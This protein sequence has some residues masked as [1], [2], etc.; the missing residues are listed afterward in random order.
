MKFSY[1]RAHSGQYL[2]LHVKSF[3]CG[4]PTEACHLRLDVQGCLCRDVTG[5]GMYHL[6]HQ[7]PGRAFTG[8]SACREPVRDK[9]KHHLSSTDSPSLTIPVFHSIPGFLIYLL[10]LHMMIL[11]RLFSFLNRNWGPAEGLHCGMALHDDFWFT[12][13][14]FSPQALSHREMLLVVHAIPSPSNSSIL[15]KEELTSID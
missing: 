9:V 5:A 3:V 12:S 2:F 13:L 1:Q 8:A 14:P 6:Q 10:H 11:E 7:I 4:Q 15:I